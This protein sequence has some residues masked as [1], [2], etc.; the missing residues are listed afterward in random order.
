MN[1]FVLIKKV[2]CVAILSLLVSCNNEQSG[3]GS[4]LDNVVTNVA[5][6]VTPFS[7]TLNGA[8]NNYS[9]GEISRGQYGFL[10]TTEPSMDA[11]AAEQL[12]KQYVS[13]GSATGCKVRYATNLLDGNSFNVTVSGFQPETTIYYCGIFIT[14]ENKTYIGG[15]QNTITKVFAPSI[16]TDA[17]PQDIGVM[18]CLLS[19]TVNLD[20]STT[21][22]C[23][24][25]MFFSTTEEGINVNGSKVVYSGKATDG[26]FSVKKDM[27]KSSTTYYY[28]S[29]LY[30]K[31]SEK[32]YLGDISSFTTKNADDYAVDLG[33]SVMWASCDLGADD[34]FEDGIPF[35]WGSV[36]PNKQGT[37][38]A[39]EHY[40]NGEYVDLGTNI[41]GTEYDAAREYWGGKWRMPTREEVEEMMI[42]C[43]I[44]VKGTWDPH[45]PYAY[46]V[47]QNG[48]SIIL[49]ANT[50]TYAYLGTQNYNGGKST[51]HRWT[52][53]LSPL[54]NTEAIYHLCDMKVADNTVLSRESSLCIRPV[55]DY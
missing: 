30:H 5:T 35:A 3:S 41:S 37:L 51:N 21:K 1:L 20:G 42:Y 55:C 10:Y 16:Q 47:A 54:D 12:F 40:V 2:L 13:E 26:T 44:E 8:I 33:L 4:K 39:Y 25:G 45:P 7:V 49:L 28:R 9:V 36:V 32:Y 14:K 50:P 43:S 6:D 52:G 11:T 29:Y 46:I 17:S 24:I 22:D 34:P 53:N 18:D 48:R 19:G 31:A 27:L 23:E 15:V 38:D